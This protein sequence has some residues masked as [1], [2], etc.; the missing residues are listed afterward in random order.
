MDHRRRFLQRACTLA[1]GQQPL[2]QQEPDLRHLHGE[3]EDLDQLTSAQQY[4]AYRLARACYAE[5]IQEA[6]YEARQH[7]QQ[8]GNG[9]SMHASSSNS[10]SMQHA[11]NAVLAGVGVSQHVPVSSGV[12]G[13]DEPSWPHAHADGGGDGG[14]AESDSGSSSSSSGSSFRSFEEAGADSSGAES[15]DAD[16]L[17]LADGEDDEMQALRAAALRQ[18]RDG[19]QGGRRLL[20]SLGYPWPVIGD[21]L[22][23]LKLQAHN[24]QHA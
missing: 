20:G 9:R 12:Q 17:H 5:S 19:R 18:G 24:R 8:G 14:G 10:A 1:A 15:A 16:G 11:G 4:M 13:S 3:I 22:C 6:Q 7:H 23:H 21:M 2:Q